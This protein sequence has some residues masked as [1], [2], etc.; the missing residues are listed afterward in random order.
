MGVAVAARAAFAQR[1]VDVKAADAIETSL[2][3]LAIVA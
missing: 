3:N 1:V 2:S